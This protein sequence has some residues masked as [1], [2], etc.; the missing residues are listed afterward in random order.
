MA[1][2]RILNTL[3]LSGAPEAVAAL[4]EL[5][6]LVS[7]P[8]ERDAVLDALPGFD[9][10][11]ASASVRIDE[12]FLARAARLRVIGSPSTGTDHM[13]VE[14]IRER[15][16][17]LFDI[18]R[19]FDLIN[20]FSATAELAFGLILS[21]VRHLP[22]AVAA[23][24]EG[25][26]ARE[27]FSGFQ[28]LGKTLGILGLGRLGNISARIGNGFAMRVIA[29]DIRAVEAPG[30]ETVDFE[31]LLHE[32]DILTIHVHLTETTRDM[33]DT[34]ALARMK[35]G[36]LLINTSRGAVVDEAALLS[37]LES[38]RLAGAGLDVIDGEWLDD[39]RGHP[40]IAYA[41]A[42]DNLVITPHIGGATTESIY[43]ARVFMARKLADF[44]R[45]EAA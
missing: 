21:L 25:D 31:T 34:G 18:A 45:A 20:S 33:I 12:E 40:L 6:E 32:S 41:K 5:G 7:L 16:I 10:Y 4:E 35:P 39:K 2:W 19:E 44:L 9:A 42:H 37:A 36:A 17:A 24:R 23:A 14:A 26:W 3:D 15:G 11:L 30:V 1:N 38:E 28:L 13:E 22:P 27:R 8:A 29:H 43:G